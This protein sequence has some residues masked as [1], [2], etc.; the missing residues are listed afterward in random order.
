MQMNVSQITGDMVMTRMV[1]R[2]MP[3][4]R[5]QPTTGCAAGG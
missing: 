2:L 5:L 1:E 4:C 3:N